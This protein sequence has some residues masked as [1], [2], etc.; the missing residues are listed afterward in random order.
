MA[1]QIA[2]IKQAYNCTQ[3]E[4]YA[5]SL[6]IMDSF[7]ANQVFFKT[8]KTTYTPAFG[9]ALR[10]EILAAK[11]LPDFQQRGEAQET[12]K[13]QMEE[14][15]SDALIIW[16][17]LE[18]LIRDS[19]P[20][21]EYKTKREAAG[22]THYA[23]AAGNDWESVSSL[24]QSGSTFIADHTADLTTGG[25]PLTF[26]ADFNAAK[27]SFDTLYG[28]FKGAEQT[29]SEKRDEKITANNNF[30]K[31]IAN[32]CED[33][34]KYY[35]NVPATRERFTFSKV[36]ELVS[37]PGISTITVTVPAGN[38]VTTDAVIANSPII[39]VGT[40]PVFVCG[41][42]AAC[43]VLTATSIPAGGQITN[44][45]GHQV[46]L[47]NSNAATDASVKLRVSNA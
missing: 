6:L 40:I 43:D 38:S 24:M 26:E 2:S 37:G 36:L 44:T 45:F 17:E 28:N 18:S 20:V 42:A 4:L 5:T 14:A 46:T 25:M 15:A 13:V 19:F 31:K 34:Q 32:L 10:A 27:S 12:F 8:K 47:T 22:Y 21:L 23:L 29:S 7:D 35:R 39:N 3:D 16:R 33:G 11:A 9:A 1:L 30:H 41:G